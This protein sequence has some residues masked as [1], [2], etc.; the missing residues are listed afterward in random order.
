MHLVGFYYKS[1]FFYLP[2]KEQFLFHCTA[3]PQL[4]FIRPS[5]ARA[6]TMQQDE[7]LC[8][9]LTVCVINIVSQIFAP[10]NFLQTVE[11]K[12]L[13]Q[14][15]TALRRIYRYNHNHFGFLIMKL[16]HLYTFSDRS[17]NSIFPVKFQ[18]HWHNYTR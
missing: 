9:L 1:I 14:I 4:F 2:S 3:S 12:I 16:C 17:L 5:T 13:L 15:I 7:L 10:H 18:S 6:F 8:S 11:T